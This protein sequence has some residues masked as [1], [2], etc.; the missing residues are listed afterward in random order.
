M[1]GSIMMIAL[2]VIVVIVVALLA[3]S[4]GKADDKGRERGKRGDEEGSGVAEKKREP[5]REDPKV[6][7]ARKELYQYLNQMIRRMFQQYRKGNWSKLTKVGVPSD[8]VQK[9]LHKIEES[10]PTPAVRLLDDL[11][12]CINLKE[13]GQNVPGT[14]TDKAKLKQVFLDMALPFYP[15]YYERLDG[16]RYTSLLN[17]TTLNLFHR[18]TGKKFRVGYKNRYSTGITAYRWEGDKY[19]VY[20]SEG[21]MLCDAV[22][23]DGKVW[24]GYA[25]L[26]VNDGEKNWEVMQEGMYKDGEFV[27]GTL[28]YIYTKDIAPDKDRVPNVPDS[29]NQ[30]T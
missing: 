2:I 30:Q 3:M 19:Q 27:D 15:V 9:H 24:E 22:F 7:E 23:R 28:H 17:Q 1:S 5:V 14:V 6:I 29:Q 11:F 12:S 8:K 26:P 4:R 16:V 18:L 21:E 20:T 25:V 13:D 10:L